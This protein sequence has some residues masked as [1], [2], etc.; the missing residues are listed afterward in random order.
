[1]A[2]FSQSV[3]SEAGRS[4]TGTTD[5]ARDRDRT[6]VPQ[7]WAILICLSLVASLGVAAF[8]AGH[9]ATPY[10][11]F[12]AAG[13]RFGF[14]D[15]ITPGHLALFAE[16]ITWRHFVEVLNPYYLLS[17]VMQIVGIV[18]VMKPLGSRGWRELFFAAQ[19]F[20]FPF[21]FLVAVLSPFMMSAGIDGESVQDGPF[22]TLCAPGAWV[23]VSILILIVSR[24]MRKDD[25]ERD[26][27]DYEVSQSASPITPS[28][29]LRAP[30]TTDQR[31]RA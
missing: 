3:F 8:E 4:A 13:N 11:S 20:V 22:N 12:D 17:L 14:N 28:R 27:S 26:A 19:P 29:I 31:L 6:F 25:P 21:A 5:T 30:M 1:M 24:M 10:W 23:L 9:N 7:T 18:L 2:V 15:P 16:N